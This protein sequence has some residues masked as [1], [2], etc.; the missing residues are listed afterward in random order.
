[1]KDV[2]TAEKA[3]ELTEKADHD[4]S[5]EVLELLFHGLSTKETVTETS[6]RG[7]G[8]SVV[9]N[10][11]D[12]VGGTVDILSPISPSGGSRFTLELPLTLAII[13]ALLVKVS[14]SVFAIPFS[15]IERIVSI[16]LSEIKSMADQFVAVVDGA[17][18]PL[19]LVG[20]IFGIDT[21]AA[22]APLMTVVVKKGPE[23]AG[24]VVD[25][26]LDEQEIIVKPLSS[27]LKGV[28]GFSGST[29]LGDGR[30]ILILD[31]ASVL[32]DTKKLLRVS[33]G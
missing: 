20:K 24:L 33:Y 21:P 23:R 11:T 29:I 12:Q 19:A 30:T 28:K 4:L 25:T 1:E 18:L 16:Q 6:G 2:I 5:R 7:V 13:K 31:V 27:I 10:F 15:S 17:N 26:L 14:D 9:K 3:D 32:E 8:L 22:V